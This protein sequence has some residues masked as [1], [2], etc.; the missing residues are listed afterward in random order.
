MIEPCR[1]ACPFFFAHVSQEQRK[2]KDALRGLCASV[3]R[4]PSLDV[5]TL[6]KQGNSSNC[7]HIDGLL[8]ETMN[9]DSVIVLKS[10]KI[11][12]WIS[13]CRPMAALLF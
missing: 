9:L 11:Q 12:G 13:G 6:T 7:P 4:K 5:I 2:T 10:F 1:K 8:G 3:V